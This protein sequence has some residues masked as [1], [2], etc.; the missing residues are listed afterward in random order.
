MGVGAGP[1][2]SEQGLT[3]LFLDG[4]ESLTTLP[5]VVGDLRGLN[6]L[7]LKKCRASAAS[8]T[9][10]NLPYLSEQGVGTLYQPDRFARCDR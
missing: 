3:W 1:W 2:P 4:I 6:S 5:D 9:I 8:S 10:A 7:H